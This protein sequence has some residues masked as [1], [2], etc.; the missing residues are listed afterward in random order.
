MVR[1]QF[2]LGG[3]DECFPHV[4][5]DGPKP[6]Q[7]RVDGVRFSPRA[8]GW[9]AVLR[10]MGHR[11]DVFPTCVGMVRSLTSWG[12]GRRSFPHVRGDGPHVHLGITLSK[13]FSPRAWGWSELRRQSSFVDVVFPTCVGMVR[14]PSGSGCYCSGF[15]HVRGDGPTRERVNARHFLFSP[16]AWGW[17][18]EYEKKS[19]SFTVFPT[20]VGMVRVNF[21]D[22][23]NA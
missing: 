19:N 7:H 13:K 17:S 22:N 9:S 4:R 3:L 8:W 20:C 10:R 18:E 21:D 23:R 6:T 5:G 14:V 11:D 1:N 15:P 2:P 12:G 16:R